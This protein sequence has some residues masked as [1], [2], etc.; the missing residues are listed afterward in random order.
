M[1]AMNTTEGPEGDGG[2][3][4]GGQSGKQSEQQQRRRST[5]WVVGLALVAVG[6]WALLRSLVHVP[7][8]GPFPFPAFALDSHAWDLLFLPALGC[9]FLAWGVV[10]RKTG[11]LVPGG[12]LAGVGLGVMA[13][14]GPFG[15]AGP[16]A[17]GG[18]ILAS[19][20]LGWAA[21]AVLAL[22]FVDRRAWWPFIP[23]VV[24]GAL[25][26]ALMTA[27]SA[28]L[29]TMCAVAV[30]AGLIAAGVIMV[31]RRRG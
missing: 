4:E 11:L 21:V 10:V 13:N 12:V 5:A 7:F 30:P 28:G 18:V 20:G 16:D 31:L 27:G 15:L 3:R 24:L 8:L 17:Q 2:A 19:M 25:G 22:S 26:V 14:Q 9:V 6:L 1:I 23:A 29:V